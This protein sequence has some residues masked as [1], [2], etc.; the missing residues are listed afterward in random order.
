LCHIRWQQV[1]TVQP[2]VQIVSWNDFGESSTD[3]LGYS[4]A[5]A[6]LEGNHKAE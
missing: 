6:V 1:W 5:L 4:G 3:A 2:E